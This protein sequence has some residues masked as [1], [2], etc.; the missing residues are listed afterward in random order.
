MHPLQPGDPAKL[1]AYD[2]TGRLTEGPRGVAYLGKESD[3]A[4]IRV[5]KLLP[6]VSD[7]R[8]D[9]IARLTGAQRVSSSYVAR[10]LDTGEHG[11]RL[12]VV[13]EHVLGHSLA[14]VV[15]HDGP[16][17]ADALERVA[18]GTL[19]A[20]TAVHLA[21]VTHRGL[22]PNNII[23]GAEGPRITDLDLGDPV[24]E[25][26]YRS[27]E[28]LQGLS[29]GPYADVYSWAAT[30]VFAATGRPPFGQDDEAGAAGEPDVGDL[31][32][33]LRR[34]VLSALAKDVGQ[35]PTTYMALLQLLGDKSGAAA[36]AVARKSSSQPGATIV[37]VPVA[38]TPAQGMPAADE[39]TVNWAQ[40][41]RGLSVPAQ[42]A[43]QPPATLEGAQ[44]PGPAQMQ[45]PPP[46]PPAQ[47]MSPIQDPPP[48]YGPPPAQAA[49]MEGVTLPPAAPMW[50]APADQAPHQSP[51]VGQTVSDRPAR[52]FPMGLAAAVGAL[53]LLSA[54]GLWGAGQYAATQKF[55]VVA[56]AAETSAP[57]TAQ[58]GGGN[59]AGVQQ[60]V[61]SQPQQSQAEVTVP[62]GQT[63][64]TDTKDVGPMELPKEWTSQPPTPPEFSTVPS[65]APTTLAP[66]A[67]PTVTAAPTV[68]VPQPTTQA[69]VT[70]TP[71]PTPPER[72]H[73]SVLGGTEP[74][75]TPTPSASSSGEGSP[76]PTVTVTVTPSDDPFD[77]QQPDSPEPTQE[78]SNPAPPDQNGGSS[79]TSARICGPGYTMADSRRFASG[80]IFLL[81]NRESAMACAVTLK[82]VELGKKTGVSVQIGTGGGA[83]QQMNVAHEFY[84]GPVRVSLKG[85]KCVQ[86]SGSVGSTGTQGSK[87]F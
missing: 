42:Q 25:P 30:M 2:L 12:Y 24:G 80:G 83:P 55:E 26:A 63:S 71:T 34:V 16:L 19:T 13:R 41:A 74:P 86:Y 70:V 33:P 1:G 66:V 49:P 10:T 17:D 11:D 59:G 37:G 22:T 43:W 44:G 54:A 14:E 18:V 65:P 87:C 35:R 4:P 39:A 48:M 60:P 8:E 20:L 64:G 81:V 76:G 45:G 46:V 61:Q 3:D 21:G 38:G 31:A 40:F 15:S 5:I 47:G 32:E 6:P 73:V 56:A 84:A 69:T 27:P 36:G 72:E 57:S 29:Y 7:A 82:G 75:P 68:T 58:E 23:M 52:K 62:W 77:P 78:P 9:D 51:V 85:G 67:P 28:Q 79:H 50:Q 53:A